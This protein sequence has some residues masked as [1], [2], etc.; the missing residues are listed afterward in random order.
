MANAQDLLEIWPKQGRWS[1]NS[2]PSPSLNPH[3]HQVWEN[4]CHRRSSSEFVAPSEG[5]GSPAVKQ[6]CQRPLA[7]KKVCPSPHDPASLTLYIW[8]RKYPQM[9]LEP[10]GTSQTEVC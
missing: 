6:T 9:R 2:I 10:H 5:W 1:V 3:L 7:S 8:K 4:R